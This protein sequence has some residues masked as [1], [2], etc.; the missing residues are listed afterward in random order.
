MRWD[1]HRIVVWTFIKPFSGWMPFISSRHQH[2]FAFSVG[3]KFVGDQPI[4]PVVLPS[5]LTD[6]VYCQFWWMICQYSC[7]MWFM[8]GWAPPHF[9]H[10]VRQHL[11]QT[12]SVQWLEHGCQVT[13]LALIICLCVLWEHINFDAFSTDHWLRDIPLT[14]RECQQFLDN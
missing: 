4:Q 10:I 5:W 8:Y 1:L 7:Y 13:P 3:V 6:T 12:F 9:L 14:C 2:Q 11:N